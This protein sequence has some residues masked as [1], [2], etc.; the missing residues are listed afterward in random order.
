MTC[1]WL[2]DHKNGVIIRIHAQPQAPRSEIVGTHGDRL[3]IR[4][5]A[6]PIDGAANEEL[7][8]FLKNLLG[9]KKNDI[10]IMRGRSSRSKDVMCYNI[11]E[12][13]ALDIIESQ[14]T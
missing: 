13:S 8:R 10:E 5:A 6:P 4:I 1:P 9:L 7:L 3:K 2:F 11:S 12:R 14:L